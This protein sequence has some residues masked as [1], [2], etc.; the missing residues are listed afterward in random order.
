[1]K[2]VNGSDC[3]INYLLHYQL[4]VATTPEEI[5]RLDALYKRGLENGVRDL[6]VI[7]PDQ[8]KEIEP[9]CVVRDVCCSSI[10]HH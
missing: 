8:I 2:T 7:G 1:M 5:P 10:T 6:K 9:N 4:I 3:F